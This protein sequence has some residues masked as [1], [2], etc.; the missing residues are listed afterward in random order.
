MT[1]T[2][3]QQAALLTV[4]SLG[5][6]ILVSA[7]LWLN[8]GRFTYSLDD[9]YIHLALA[10]NLAEGHY[11]LNSGEPSSPSSSILWPFLLAP[12]AGL[13]SFELMP[14]L[15]ALLSMG[16]VLV[17]LWS[18][19][20]ERL[21][22]HLS[23]RARCLVLLLVAI[24]CNLWGMPLNGMEHSL[25]LLLAVWVAIGLLELVEDGRVAPT[26]LAGLVIGP[27][28]R[29]ENTS[30]LVMGA[31]VLWLRGMRGKAALVLGSSAAGIAAFAAF[32]QAQGLPWL[33]SSVLVKSQVAAAE[34]LV[35]LLLEIGENLLEG[36]AKDRNWVLLTLLALLYRRLRKNPAGQRTAN[37][38]LYLLFLSGILAAH[39]TLGRYDWLG[40]YEIYL[41]LTAAVLLLFIFRRQ[42]QGLIASRR[43]AALAGLVAI[44][45][46]AGK[47]QIY[48]TIMTPLSASNIYTVN[49]QMRRFTVDYWRDS[50]GSTDVGR[51][52]LDNPYPVLDL[53]G[54]GSEEARRSRLS[55][56]DNTWA[57]RLA[58]KH[59]VDLLIL[60]EGWFTDRG[61]LPASW[62]KVGQLGLREP[63]GHGGATHSFL[64]RDPARRE[65]LVQD[66]LALRPG[67][68]PR[69]ELRVSASPGQSVDDPTTALR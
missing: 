64:L 57:E 62:E 29:F 40:R 11:G 19:L 60:D 56:S 9:A 63:R 48:A 43:W 36:L 6:A 45:L 26:F 58:A 21:S 35:R 18:F 5:V 25:Q 22:D 66:L 68:P 47:N 37:D 30:L 28:V 16:A 46:V 14:L 49:H 31:A 12:F 59:E 38:R 33:P 2:S 61:P 13:E 24:G 69:A 4:Y 54:L 34:G 50:V 65:E 23:L 8:Q 27:L 41:L 17:A 1:R 67:L 20:H 15:L 52:S 53:W 51:L 7:T 44:A 10:D 3:Q 42:L 39:M 32:L 55:A